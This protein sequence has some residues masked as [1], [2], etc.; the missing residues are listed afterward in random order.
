MT[1]NNNSQKNNEE[2][3]DRLSKVSHEMRT[4]LNAVL[5]MSD[6]ILRATGGDNV[7]ISEIQSFAKDIKNAGEELLLLTS[8]Y[9]YISDV[10]PDQADNNTVLTVKNAE[11]AENNSVQT[12]NNARQADTKYVPLFHA[13]DAKILLVD[14]NSVNRR[15]FKNLLR[16]TEISIDE[17]L[18]GFDCIARTSKTKYDLIFLDYMMPDQDGVKTLEKIRDEKG[19]NRNTPVIALTASTTAA[20]KEKLERSGFDDILSKPIIS[21][22]LERVVAAHLPKEKIR[23]C[24]S[25]YEKK[26][27]ENRSENSRSDE[28]V[29]IDIAR[30]YANDREELEGYFRDIQGGDGDGFY[31]YAVKIHSMKTSALMVKA[32]EPWA[33]AKSLE[34]AAENENADFIISVHPVFV[35][36]W[37]QM[38]E[39]LEKDYLYA[40]ERDRALTPEYEII[41]NYL[42]LLTKAVEDIDIDSADTLM[43]MIRSYWYP[44]ELA[45]LISRLNS[46]VAGLD[47]DATEQYV[48]S[49]ER[50]INENYITDRKN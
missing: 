41:L 38:G 48:S 44:D 15:V 7:D 8:D 45:I 20:T 43:E 12:D 17:A 27:N 13:P 50:I 24:G 21:E 31:Q 1:E 19:A 30:V 36:S 46:A 35:K 5:G 2:H 10:R 40:R 37:M 39:Q 34:E 14:D 18:G 11:Q 26:V 49:I 28:L 9:L 29:A 16:E 22:E 47:A 25:T 6:M 4:P 32:Y 3:E 23:D 33:L 42:S